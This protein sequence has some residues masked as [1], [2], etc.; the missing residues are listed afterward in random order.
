[1][2]HVETLGLQSQIPVGTKLMPLS[3]V[4]VVT[5]SAETLERGI[6]KDLDMISLLNLSNVLNNINKLICYDF[7]KLGIMISKYLRWF[8]IIRFHYESL[9]LIKAAFI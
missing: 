2:L 9:L 5:L 7:Y 1:V 6:W 8:G 3:A 4:N